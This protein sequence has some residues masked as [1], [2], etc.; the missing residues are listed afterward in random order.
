MTF[1]LKHSNGL[2]CSQS[3]ELRS[4]HKGTKGPAWS[5]PAHWLPLCFHLWLSLTHFSAVILDSFQFTHS[6]GLPY[7]WVFALAISSGQKALTLAI[8]MAYSFSFFRSWLKCSFPELTILNSNPILPQPA[9]LPPTPCFSPYHLPASNV[10]WI[11]F[12][13]F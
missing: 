9:C 2:D 11:L 7:P 3:K 8:Q 12:L 10:Q 6:L 13:C 4:S 1:S 5:A